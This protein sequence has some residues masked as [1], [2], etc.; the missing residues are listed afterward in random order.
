MNCAP[1]KKGYQVLQV[2]EFLYVGRSVREVSEV[3][4]TPVSTLYRWIKRFNERG[5]D[6]LVFKGGGGRPR[7]IAV[8][9]FEA[10]YVPILLEPQKA[11]EENFTALKFHQYLKEECKEQL[12]YQTLLNYLHEMKLSRVVPRP[13]VT[14]KQNEEERDGFL[15]ALKQ[16][17][18]EQQEVWFGDEVG[19]EGDPRPRA[20]WVKVGSK[21]VAGRA[22]EH[23]RYSAIG[24]VHPESGEFVSLLVPEVDTIVFQTYL[25]EFSKATK[26]RK[27]TLVLDNASWHKVKTLDWH[28]ITPLFLPPY[29]PDLNPIENLW[30]YIKLNYFS[31][32]FARNIEQLIDKLCFAFKSISDNKRQIS[33]TTT[34][35]NFNKLK[36]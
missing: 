26:G 5:L 1:S 8:E 6:G 23:L 27:I 28:N 22:S 30:R 4:H 10:E 17:Y 25:N 24:A 13:S 35:K 36:C 32:W 11:R 33:S 20:R 31:N 12:C 15:A 19:F 9:K 14:G 2:L 7:K 29:S 16:V 3:L 18:K 34:F 21:P